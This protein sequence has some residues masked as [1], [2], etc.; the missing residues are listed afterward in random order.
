MDASDTRIEL[1]GLRLDAAIGVYPHEHARRQPLDI[2]LALTLDGTLAARSDELAHTIDY[3]EVVRCLEALLA[4]RHY[5]LLEHLSQVML[6]AL[7]QRFPIEHAELALSKPQ[8]VPQAR[9][10]VVRRVASWKREAVRAVVG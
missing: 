3:D 7:G 6:D 5:Q 8:A 9:K 4:A 10:V 2:D 1:H